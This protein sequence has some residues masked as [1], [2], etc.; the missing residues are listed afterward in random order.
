MRTKIPKEVLRLRRYYA[1]Y[2][3]SFVERVGAAAG[4]VLFSRRVYILSNSENNPH[5]VLMQ[6]ALAAGRIDS[7]IISPESY[8]ARFCRIP[9]VV[10]PGKE[11]TLP[12]EYFLL[13]TRDLSSGKSVDEGYLRILRKAAAVLDCSIPNIERLVEEGISYTKL[14]YLPWN[15]AAWHFLSRFLL[16]TNH[17]GYSEFVQKD[18][19]SPS[20]DEKTPVC[21][22]LPETT[23]RRRAFRDQ[24]VN[25]RFFEGLRHK[26]AWVG[27]GMSYKYLCKL[28]LDRGLEYII[29]VEDD[30]LLSDRFEQELEVVLSYLSLAP[31]SWH[32]FSGFIAD[33]SKNVVVSK[34]VSYRAVDFVHLNKF[35]SM[36]CNIYHR[37]VFK[38]LSQW[39]EQNYHFYTNTIDRFLGNW[40]DLKVI[41]T[42][43]FL[44]GHKEELD[45]SI[46]NFNNT[47]YTPMVVETARRMSSIVRA[48]RS[49]E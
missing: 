22:S 7:T 25:F 5:A 13:Q 8:S 32:V 26:Y 6:K 37:S 45:S 35:T 39:D 44:A 36:V 19:P 4:R 18:R 31:D 48:F 16:A 1:R 15:D 10:D 30:A 11:A 38:K 21:L 42:F 33:L 41:T 3:T 40:R 47:R 43:P 17:I 29:I 9:V 2:V 34:V 20:F 23:E 14:F 46:W 28:A 12:K 49:G 24:H 27:C